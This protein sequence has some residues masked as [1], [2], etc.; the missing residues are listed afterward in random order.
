MHLTLN[1]HN[2]EEQ[3]M[4]GLGNF[5]PLIKCML[6]MALIFSAFTDLL[7]H[8]DMTVDLGLSAMKLAL[9]HDR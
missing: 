2:L 1:K 8:G 9:K 6:F 3:Y 5:F 7:K 4:S